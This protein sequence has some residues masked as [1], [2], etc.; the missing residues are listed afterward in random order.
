VVTAKLIRR[1]PAQCVQ[2]DRLAAQRRVHG[3]TALGLRRARNPLLLGQVRRRQ[4]IDQSGKPSERELVGEAHRACL[5]LSGQL[6]ARDALV[7]RVGEGTVAEMT[8]PQQRAERYIV[9]DH[10][11]DL[12]HELRRRGHA[13]QRLA[14]A[15]TIDESEQCHT[16]RAVR[17]G[18]AQRIDRGLGHLSVQHHGDVMGDRVGVVDDRVGGP[19]QRCLGGCAGHGSHT[20]AR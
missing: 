6:R 7:P 1:G 15:P 3:F 5:E 12:E 8:D 20:P 9:A 2:I 14:P 17:L 16:N 10:H 19:A 4:P 11:A 13:L 18:E